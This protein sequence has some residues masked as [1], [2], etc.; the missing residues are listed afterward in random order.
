M[1]QDSII[2]YTTPDLK[3]LLITKK[4]DLSDGHKPEVEEFIDIF[5]AVYKA[6]YR[7]INF[8]SQKLLCGDSFIALF[9]NSETF[10]GQLLKPIYEAALIGIKPPSIILV[11]KKLEALYRGAK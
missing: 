1:K 6:G 11:L 2:F 4:S 8:D 10:E 7:G 3:N 5:I 9:F